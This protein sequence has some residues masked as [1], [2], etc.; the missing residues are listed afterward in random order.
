V[1]QSCNRRGS[2]RG[3]GVTF[4]AGF[5]KFIPERRGLDGSQERME[6]SL[7][8]GNGRDGTLEGLVIPFCFVR[9]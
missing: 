6:R 9:L 4:N 1:L 5:A 2:A 7:P 8:R 3:A